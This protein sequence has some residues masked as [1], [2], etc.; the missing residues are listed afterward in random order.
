M[1]T[2]P[3]P[4]EGKTTIAANL[5]SAY[6]RQGKRILLID[7]NFSHPSLH[8]LLKLNNEHGF[9]EIL[10]G[11]KEITPQ[12]YYNEDE[13]SFL[14]LPVGEFDLPNELYQVEKVVKVLSNLQKQAD[15]IIL[16]SPPLTSADASLLAALAGGVLFII[17]SGHT[18]IS[19]AVSATQQ[20]RRQGAQIL[21][22]VVNCDPEV[23]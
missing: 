3:G 2:S 6:S 20:L 5:A 7:A 4:G 14:V 19:S 1:V 23:Q 15:L 21:G 9:S 10:H 12:R 11:G 8:S 16:D 18:E 22:I 17:K 13:S